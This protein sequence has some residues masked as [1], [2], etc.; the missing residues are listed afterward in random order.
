MALPIMPTKLYIPPPRPDL[1]AR[2]RL[3]DRLDGGLQAGSQLTVVMGPAGSGKTTL[4]TS[5]IY[6]PTRSIASRA[7]AWLSLDRD[8]N[9][10]VRFLSHLIAALRQFDPRVGRGVESLLGSPQMPALRGLMG[11]LMAEL[12]SATTP[13]VLVLDDYQLVTATEIHEAIERF[14]AYQPAQIHLV[15]ISRE[16]PPFALAP[17]R[18]RDVVTEIDGRDLRFTREETK[19]LLE[20]A[21]GSPLP[22]ESVD[23]ALARTEGWAAGLQ[24]LLLA[25]RRRPEATPTLPSSVPASLTDGDP[26][27]ADYLIAEVLPQQP[28]DIQTFLRDTSLLTQLSGSLCDHVARREGSDALLA[29]LAAKG[30]F[31]VPL[32]TQ[33]RWYRYHRLFAEVLSGT[34]IPERQESVHRRALTWYD[35]NAMPAYAIHHALAVGELSDDWQAAARLI[36]RHGEDTA[37]RGEVI[38][39]KGWL[40]AL[41]ERLV[42]TDAGLVTMKAWLAAMSGDLVDA[43][44]LARVA[45]DLLETDPEPAAPTGRSSAAKLQAV[46]SFV[47][48]LKDGDNVRA[49]TLADEALRQLPERAVDWRILALW[50]RAEAQERLNHLTAAIDALWEAQRLGRSKRETLFAVVVEGGLVKSLNDQGRRRDALAVCQ[51]ALRHYRDAQ[52]APLPLVG[53]IFSQL[54]VLE[55]E[56]NELAAAQATHAQALALAEPLGL[57]YELVYQRALAAPTWYALGEAEGALAALREGYQQAVQDGYADPDWF[58]AWE[59]NIRLWQGDIVFA[60]HWARQAGL[61]PEDEPCLL[62]IEHHITYARYLVVERRDN[63]ARRWLASLERFTRTHDLYRWLITVNILQAILADRTGDRA[64]AQDLLTRAVQTAAPEGYLRPFLVEGTRAVA[65]LSHLRGVA[66]DFIDRVRG[67]A[68][69]T[70]VRIGTQ[71]PA[72]VEP[73]TEREL[74]VLKLIAA[75]AANRE[76]AEQLVIAVGTVKRHT[77]HIYGKLQ[78][79]SRTEAV[80]RARELGLL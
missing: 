77:N 53:Y 26:Y 14:L 64:S 58:L 46:R 49:T 7:L 39:V 59:T 54:G 34:L 42:D 19:R 24:L 69:A 68:D 37:R 62:R 50:T 11:S 57:A 21:L 47:V 55:Y 5:W 33:G 67:A 35:Q 13:G 1:V 25:A 12:A 3:L 4:I 32:D 51:D 72:L 8:D 43:D 27:V 70:N 22:D 20:E 16:R 10:P 56:A 63:E 74:E 9:D 75:G 52:G 44:A 28:A 23:Q 36:R 29:D 65:L 73:L 61:S 40:E 79:H 80:A 41:P 78:V 30:F 18:V 6:S 15:V 60:R 2:P 38:T 76:I 31:V 45:G 48:L 71:V 17:M 66:P